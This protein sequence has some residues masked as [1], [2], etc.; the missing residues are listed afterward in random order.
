MSKIIIMGVK[1]N[2]P[3]SFQKV[4]TI[5]NNSNAKN[6][7]ILLEYDMLRYKKHR[8][9][10]ITARFFSGIFGL[11]K[12]RFYEFYHLTEYLKK[13][14]FK[15]KYIDIKGIKL[16]KQFYRDSNIKDLFR[17]AT[18]GSNN[19]N[20]PVFEEYFIKK[21]ETA[22]IEEISKDCLKES[23]KKVYVILG[24]DHLDSMKKRLSSKGIECT[25]L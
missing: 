16:A 11:K 18:T 5:L 13:E 17:M 1:H 24:N 19:T 6:A 4:K 21:R 2:N 25:V 12:T 8:R 3:T 22:M 10:T 7:L 9:K 20:N 23:I 14:G 15:F